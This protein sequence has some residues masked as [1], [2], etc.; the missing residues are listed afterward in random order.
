MMIISV[1]ISFYHALT[2][3]FMGGR[4]PGG[5]KKKPVDTTKYY[6]LLNVSKDAT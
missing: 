5:Q 3:N 4:V 2:E 1:R 6:N